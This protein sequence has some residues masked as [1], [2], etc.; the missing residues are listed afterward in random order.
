[1]AQQ[2]RLPFRKWVPRWLGIVAAFTV[3]IPILLI[4]GSYTGS[5]ID[6]SG[7]LGVL[8]EDINM[9]YYAASA[10]MAVAYPLLPKIRPIVTTKTILLTDLIL[11][12]V[13]SLICARTIHIEIITICS[14]FIGFLKAF[15]MIET[16]LILKPFFSPKDVRSEFYGYFY[17]IVFSIGQLSMVITA[18]L[19]YNYQW[20]YMYYFIIILLL[21]AIIFVLTCFRYGRRPIAI[22]FRD[23]DWQS[24]I[25]IS[26]IMLI[27]LYVTTY[28]KTNNWFVS[29]KI[30][31]ATLM[32]PFLL[33]IFIHRQQQNENPYLRLEV[34]SSP[35]AIIGYLFM[36][37]VMFFSASSSILSSY[38]TSVLRIDSIHSNN[39]NL[40]MIPGYIVGAALSFWWLRLQIF[41]FRVLIFWGMSFFV[42]YLAILYFGLTPTGTYEFLRLP[43]LL[44]GAG[45]M[46]LFIAFGVY[47]VEDL[48]PQ[49]MIYNAFF[50]IG[51]RSAIAPAVSASFFSNMIY[52]MQQQNLTILSENIEWQNP[53]AATRYTQ[54]LNSALAQGNSLQDAHQLAT[55][56]LYSAVQVQSLILSLKILLGYVLLFAILVMIISRFIPF[57]RTLKVKVVK[58]GEDM[59]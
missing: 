14:F 23:I 17:P 49:L 9:A 12:V 8:S 15:A 29:D 22:P 24:V 41:R 55:N 48:K 58:T 19:A 45:M 6:I 32:L 7:A 52:R 44:R 57:H 35:K 59:A 38:T 56:T 40:W 5:S 53:L 18:Q 54:S 34:L 31:I 2:K 43:M 42:A 3:M 30:L 27:I 1:M 28:G 13:F 39:L 16:I 10:G 46:T 33:W 51:V 21:I 47:A 25:L 4:N 20:Q 26:T 50:L 37:L 11:Q 36:S